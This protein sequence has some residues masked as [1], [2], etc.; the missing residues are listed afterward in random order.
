MMTYRENLFYSVGIIAG[1]FS[2]ILALLIFRAF[3]LIHG[4]KIW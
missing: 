2:L 4:I 3:G 1:Y